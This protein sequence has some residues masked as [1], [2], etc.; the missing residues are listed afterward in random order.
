M[1]FV[2]RHFWMEGDRRDVAAQDGQV[3]CCISLHFT[4][5]P[6]R[7]RARCESLK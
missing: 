3:L 7:C 6:C 5:V 1:D 4:I 2:P